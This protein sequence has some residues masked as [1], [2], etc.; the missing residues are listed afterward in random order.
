MQFAVFIK[1]YLGRFISFYCNYFLFVLRH[2]TM[3][4]YY[5]IILM[6]MNVDRW[7]RILFYLFN[8]FS[9]PTN[10]SSTFDYGNMRTL[11]ESIAVDSFGNRMNQSCR[12]SYLF[13]SMHSIYD[14]L[15]FAQNILKNYGPIKVKKRHKFWSNTILQ[16]IGKFVLICAGNFNL[17][18]FI[19]FFPF[20]FVAFL[21][22]LF[23]FGQTKMKSQ[24]YTNILV[25]IPVG[26]WFEM[27]CG[28]TIK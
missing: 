10:N 27:P 9:H 24:R 22:D 20:C 7:L 18:I 25:H 6:N 11:T 23:H 15:L 14:I 16:F 28:R 12:I 1:A 4:N 3:S 21:L 26:Q 8:A 13:A 17:I 2:E 5:I 19:L